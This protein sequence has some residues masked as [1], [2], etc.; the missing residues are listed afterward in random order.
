MD[1]QFLAL[2]QTGKTRSGSYHNTLGCNSKFGGKTTK[3][4]NGLRPKMARP[5]ARPQEEAGGC[6][7]PWKWSLM[8]LVY[9]KLPHLL[10]VPRKWSLSGPVSRTRPGISMVPRK[11]SLMVLPL[12]AVVVLGV[13]PCGSAGQDTSIK[14]RQGSVQGVLRQSS[15]RQIYAYLGI[16]YAKPPLKDLRFQPPQR[17]DGW[18]STL[19]ASEFGAA[20]PQPFLTGVQISEDC[21]TLNVWI[22]EL[23]RGFRQYPVVVLV[24]GEMFITSAPSRF[25]G[26]DLAASDLIVVSI[27]YRTNAFGFLTWQ[28]R[29]LPGNLG[30]RDQSLALEWVAENIE[31]FGGDLGRV[32]LLGHSAGAASAA[33][34]LVHPRSQGPFKQM[35]LLSGSNLSPWALSRRPRDAARRLSERV[36]CGYV[37]GS[38]YLLECLKTKDVNQIV[39][40]VE[41]LI[42]E[43]NP[44]YL[45]APVVDTYLPQK[46]RMV[47]LEPLRAVK[48][49]AN[50]RIPVLLG[51]SEN[52]GSVMLYIKREISHMTYDDLNRY[53]HEILVP[54]LTSLA[55]LGNGAA[56]INKMVEYAYLDRA[57]VGK[58]DELVLEIVKMFTDGM[59]KAPVAKLTEEVSSRGLTTYLFVNTFFAR[60]IYD[61]HTNITGA[62]HGAELAYLFAPAAYRQ[63]FNLPL[64][65]P[66]ER[67]SQ[68]LKRMVFSFASNRIPYLGQYSPRWGR[69]TPES[70]TYAS[71][72]SGQVH[73]AYQ[74]HQIAFWNDLLPQL[75]YLATLNPDG[76]PTTGTEEPTTDSQIITPGTENASYQSAVWVL[77]AV[78]LL[79]I[80]VIIVYIVCSRRRQMIDSST[81]RDQ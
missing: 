61:S 49:N 69:F 17:H 14:L 39:K 45:F 44:Y 35:I 57:P 19:Y 11:W 56:A 13:G 46:G 74:H 34:H 23:P 9:R 12:M 3:K 24:E 76:K 6:I 15:S 58:K 28:D 53:G 42:E 73:Q 7:V 65:F 2:I 59:F 52:D 25:P 5:P 20:C 55:N 38:T 79:L 67:I 21:L 77:A 60:D 30:L 26:Q 63:I 18:T 50:R 54:L 4:S 32:T 75:G 62:L 33:Y 36:G 40:A 37:S 78:I 70:P 41:R 27:N 71:L 64:T 10:T 81:L 43:G 22:P 16:P 66:E 8:L 72:E 80:T 47:P 1:A 51:L 31:K 68:S 29:V 48:E